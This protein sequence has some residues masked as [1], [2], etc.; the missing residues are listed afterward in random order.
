M[1][2]DI[3]LV[4]PLQESLLDLHKDFS[5]TKKHEV[6]LV[7]FSDELEGKLVRKIGATTQYT[8]GII[9]ATEHRIEVKSTN[10]KE[11]GAKLSHLAATCSSPLV[12]FNTY[13]CDHACTNILF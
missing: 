1:F 7:Q 12:A 3:A 5:P 4:G 13:E 6:A 8:E 9:L 11:T 2:V 10:D